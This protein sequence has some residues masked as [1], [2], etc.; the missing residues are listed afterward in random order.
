[1]QIFFFFGGKIYADLNLNHDSRISPIYFHFGNL[2]NHS[3]IKFVIGKIDKDNC[4]PLLL[5]VQLGYR[6]HLNY[7]QYEIT[8]LPI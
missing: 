4:C 5:I 3:L 6:I 1:M 7:E 2:L 8:D